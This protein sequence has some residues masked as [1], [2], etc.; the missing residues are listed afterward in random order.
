M[1]GGRV[2]HF[3]ALRTDKERLEKARSDKDGNSTTETE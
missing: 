1:K 3:G 2:M